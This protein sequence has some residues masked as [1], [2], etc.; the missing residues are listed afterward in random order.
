MTD[1]SFRFG[2]RCGSRKHR[3]PAGST[4]KELLSASPIERVTIVLMIPLGRNAELAALTIRRRESRISMS[5]SA[6]LAFSVRTARSEGAA[7]DDIDRASPSESFI[8]ILNIRP[9][10][11]YND[12]WVV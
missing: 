12:G 8:L 9:V 7:A 1:A 3:R 10:V 6:I 11:K 5:Q 2:G 4:E